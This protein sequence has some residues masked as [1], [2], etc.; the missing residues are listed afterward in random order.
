[1]GTFWLAHLHFSKTAAVVLLILISSG[2]IKGPVSI[3]RDPSLHQDGSNAVKEGSTGR[4]C[5]S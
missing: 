4:I 5:I 1:M 2:R 3:I